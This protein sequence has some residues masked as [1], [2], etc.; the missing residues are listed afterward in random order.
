MST[1]LT[2]KY[3]K[4]FEKCPTELPG[5][6]LCKAVVN[7]WD[8]TEWNDEEECDGRVLKKQYANRLAFV[9]DASDYSAY[10]YTFPNFGCVQYEPNLIKS[11][12]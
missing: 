10:L 2:C 9:R 1:C 5:L 8:S 4:K 11:Q 12:D 6:G 7:Y 3:W